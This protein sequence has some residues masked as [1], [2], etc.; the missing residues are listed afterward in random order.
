MNEMKLVLLPPTLEIS[1]SHQHIINQTV[2]YVK[3]VLN[4][5]KTGHDWWHI[6]RVWQ[7]ALYIA[8]EEQADLFIVQLAALLHDI[9]DW[10]FHNGDDKASAKIAQKWLEN[11]GLE[12]SI[13]SHVYD[14]INE[15]TFKGAGV[16]N[17]I[18][19]LEGKIVQ[20]ADRLDAL[21]AIGIARAFTYGGYKG[22]PMHNPTLEPKLHSSF[23]EYKKHKGSTVN[24]FYEK[25]LLLKDLMNTNTGR[26]LAET[27]HQFMENFLNQFFLDWG[28]IDEV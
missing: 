8:N 12:E 3:R 17:Q 5:D 1:I 25:L 23:E 19:T 10:K 24:H 7:T 27:R 11:I 21:G 26:K 14:I 4:H 16:K 2:A 9:A 15:V 18:K 22:L 13:I 28:S 20:D 6:H